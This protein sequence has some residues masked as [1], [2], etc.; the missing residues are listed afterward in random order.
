MILSKWLN[1]LNLKP[2][3]NLLFLGILSNMSKQVFYIMCG[4]P[5]SGK[6]TLTKE[7]V[8]RFG[9]S[10]GSMD[11]VL[12]ERN[13]EVE[14]M[15]QDDWNYVY[16]EGYERL[17]RL[18][19]EGKTVILDSGA[20]K[21]SERN[22]ARA[23][24]ADFEVPTKLIYINTSKEEIQKRWLKNQETKKRGH[25]EEVSLNKAM[26]MFNEPTTDEDPIIYNQTMDLDQWIK[27][28]IKI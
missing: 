9:F 6:S 26:D 4:L 22:T 16:S 8:E 15:T 19:K 25:L 17:K 10:V 14:K 5:Y 2:P 18:L 28:N 3:P 27:D 21:L 1:G 20:L 11:A 13:F 24:A 12:D 7:L 23:I